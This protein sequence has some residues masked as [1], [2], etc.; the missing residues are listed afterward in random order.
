M[1]SYKFDLAGDDMTTMK[2]RTI[3]VPHSV[4]CYTLDQD[5]P[6]STFSQD[7]PGSTFSQGKS[8]FLTAF[9]SL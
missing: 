5:F 8:F 4:E 1:K 2:L 9:G 7:I 6:G 3:E